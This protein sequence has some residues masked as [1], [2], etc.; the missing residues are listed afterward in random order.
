[1]INLEATPVI[2]NVTCFGPVS[3]AGCLNCVY[4]VIRA[5]STDCL[6]HPFPA[7]ESQSVVSRILT[8]KN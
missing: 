2:V 6:S 5:T 8:A 7:Q 1:M 4:Q 3:L